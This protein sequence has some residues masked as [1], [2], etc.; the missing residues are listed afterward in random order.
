MKKK[1]IKPT[2]ENVAINMENIMATSGPLSA[3]QNK[4][5]I[6]DWNSNRKGGWNSTNW[7]DTDEAE[8]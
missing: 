4:G 6:D 1:Y 3:K 5:L 7:T 2:S 8:D